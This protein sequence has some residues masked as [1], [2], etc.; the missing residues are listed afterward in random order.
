MPD[1]P[2]LLQLAASIHYELSQWDEVACLWPIVSRRVPQR[3]PAALCIAGAL[4]ALERYKESLE[5]CDRLIAECPDDDHAEMRAH[6]LSAGIELAHLL[7]RGAGGHI[8]VLGL[9][10]QQQI[11]HAAPGQQGLESGTGQFPDNAF[12]GL[13][14]CVGHFSSQRS[15]FSG[16]PSQVLNGVPGLH[17]AVARR[18]GQAEC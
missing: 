5:V 8:V 17:E 1:D 13:S 4:L 3:R 7:G 15:A 18:I 10:A 9:N 11:A 2:H 16:Q 6:F 14:G 12:S